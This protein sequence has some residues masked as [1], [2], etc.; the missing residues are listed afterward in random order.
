MV[1]VQVDLL[2]GLEKYQLEAL[3]RRVPI[4]IAD[5]ESIVDVLSCEDLILHKLLAGRMIDL[6]D[7]VAL[8]KANRRSLDFTYLIH[9]V[10]ENSL[11][12][13]FARVWQEAFPGEPFPRAER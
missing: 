11:R 8:L 3:S 6:A 4:T 1:D 9:W 7:A 12:A 2:L 5:F 13:E 10:D